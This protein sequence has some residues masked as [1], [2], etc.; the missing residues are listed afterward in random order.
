VVGRRALLVIVALSTCA[1]LAACALYDSSLLLPATDTASDAGADAD[2]D[3]DS[4]DSGAATCGHL[5][6]P[7]RPT[8]EDGTLDLDFVLAASRLRVFPT[9][10]VGFVHPGPPIGFDLDGVCTCPGPESC[11]PIGGQRHCDGDGG[12]DDSTGNIFATFGTLAP[13]TFSDDAFNALAAKGIANLLLRVRSYNGGL[14][15]KQVT[16][17]VYVSAGLDGIQDGGLP[18]HLPLDD[19]TDVWTI[20]PSSLLGGATVDGGPSCEGNDNVC[21]PLYAD[22]EAYVSNGVLVAHVDFPLTAGAG[23]DTIVIKVS[24][25]VIAAPLI[26]GDGGRYYVEEGQ[27]GGRW[28][29][30]DML[31]ALSNVKDPFDVNGNLCG[32]ASTYLNAKQIVC[33]ASDVTAIPAADNTG[34]PCDALSLAMSFSDVPA[35]LG[36]IYAAVPRPTQCPNWKDDCS[37]VK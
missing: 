12:T 14:D 29:T 10:A 11:T 8:Q 13:A 28:H 15:D 22:T 3:A 4:A 32:D 31:S 24:G 7:S 19:G 37:S 18:P 35:H 6:V 16:A 1:A 30:A 26:K 33:K 2:H 9:G 20:D 21:V 27:L 36:P 17:I 25:G 34:Q 5:Q 23:T